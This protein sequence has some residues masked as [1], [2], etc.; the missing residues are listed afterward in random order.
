MIIYGK[1]DDETVQLTS[2]ATGLSEVDVRFMLAVGRGESA[3]DIISLDDSDISPVTAA[4]LDRLRDLIDKQIDTSDIPEATGPVARIQ[5]DEHGRLPKHR[6]RTLP[7]EKLRDDLAARF[8]DAVL[9]IDAPDDNAGGVW[10]LDVRV[11]NGDQW[12]VVEWK[13]GGGFFV[14]TPG[15]DDYGTKPD[16][17]YQDTGQAFDR[18]IQLLVSGIKTGGDTSPHAERHG[19]D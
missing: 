18:V 11:G 8:P 10:L 3:G 1:D 19:V 5:H 2:Q 15:P 13:A 7:I 14:S 12:I 17:F 6:E 4:S 9:D 16:K